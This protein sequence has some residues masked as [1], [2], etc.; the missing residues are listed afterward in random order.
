MY[1]ATPANWPRR[2]A[3]WCRIVR[4]DSKGRLPVRCRNWEPWNLSDKTSLG[5]CRSCECKKWEIRNRFDT[6][7]TRE[8]A[9]ILD[10]LISMAD[11][12]DGLN[13]NIYFLLNIDYVFNITK[14]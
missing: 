11:K 1:E 6:K 10:V 13:E 3:V 5:I 8:S 2:V 7:E 14:S 4:A 12:I 9:R